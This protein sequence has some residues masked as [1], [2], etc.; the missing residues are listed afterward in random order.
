MKNFGEDSLKQDAVAASD[1]D[2]DSAFSKYNTLFDPFVESVQA[3]I[4]NGL[5][6]LVPETAE[7]IKSRNEMLS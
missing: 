7:K 3:T 2:Y 1:D 6:F 4:T 5:D